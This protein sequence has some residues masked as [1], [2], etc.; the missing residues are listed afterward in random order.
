MASQRLKRSSECSTVFILDDQFK[1]LELKLALFEETHNILEESSVYNCIQSTAT[2]PVSQDSWQKTVFQVHSS[3]CSGHNLQ[4]SGF[5]RRWR[6]PTGNFAK[7]KIRFGSHVYQ[8]GSSPNK[9]ICSVTPLNH[10][11]LKWN[12]KV[13]P[14]QRWGSWSIWKCLGLF[15]FRQ[16]I[17]MEDVSHSSI[18]QSIPL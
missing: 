4:R 6:V 7:L 12:L 16:H 1:C 8:L 18:M 13:P 15:K 2:L 3:S 5:K 10:L 11:I 9:F 17:I 14:M